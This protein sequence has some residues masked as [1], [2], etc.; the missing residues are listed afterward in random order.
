LRRFVQSLLFG[1]CHDGRF[2]DR[3]RLPCLH[4]VV[5][6]WWGWY[7]EYNH[8]DHYNHYNHYNTATATAAVW[9]ILYRCSLLQ[10]ER[11]RWDRPALQRLLQ[12]TKRDLV[13][14]AQHDNLAPQSWRFS[15][16]GHGQRSVYSRAARS[17][18][19]RCAAGDVIDSLPERCGTLHGLWE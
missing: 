14:D 9:T 6:L 1:S 17:V 12:H 4:H 3:S 11:Q 10:E 5:W 7:H 13:H 15:R 18:R 8:H 16:L 2:G 19:E